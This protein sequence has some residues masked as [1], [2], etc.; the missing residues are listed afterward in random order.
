MNAAVTLPES[1]PGRFYALI[2][3]LNL[4]GQTLEEV[5]FIG[6]PY[7][8]R[9]IVDGVKVIHTDTEGLSNG[10][11]IDLQEWDANAPEA[12]V[13]ASATTELVAANSNLKF[14]AKQGGAAG[15]DIIVWPQLTGNPDD[16]LSVSVDGTTINIVIASNGSAEATSTA[17]D[18]KA[19]IENFPAAAALVDV[20]FAPGNDGSGVMAVLGIPYQLAGGANAFSGESVQTI[21]NVALGDTATT[22]TVESPAIPATAKITRDGSKLRIY[23]AGQPTATKDIADILVTGLLL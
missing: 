5:T 12:D 14:T 22:G 11:T 15:N 4:K 21:V 6:L 1:R 7:N 8:A 17:A 13:P 23:P 9:A 18:V 16:E 20:A 19:A 2:R 3:G 10:A